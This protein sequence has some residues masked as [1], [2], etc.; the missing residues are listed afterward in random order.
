MHS[1][2]FP[3]IINTNSNVVLETTSAFWRDADKF[4]L[5]KRGDRFLEKQVIVFHS[6]LLVGRGDGEKVDGW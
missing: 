5:C 1:R 2:R 3:R 6:S 4:H